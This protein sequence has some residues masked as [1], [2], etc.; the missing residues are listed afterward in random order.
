MY[1]LCFD[2]RC[3][4][5]DRE[6]AN[7]GGNSDGLDEVKSSLGEWYDTWFMVYCECDSLT[8]YD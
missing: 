6:H 8:R 2:S 1:L 5:L 3:K 4:E 7:G